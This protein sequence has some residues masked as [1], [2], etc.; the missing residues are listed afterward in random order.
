MGPAEAPALFRTNTQINE[1]I[2]PWFWEGTI[3]MLK[4]RKGCRAVNPNLAPVLP[5]QPLLDAQEGGKF[6][7]PQFPLASA[8]QDVG[9][10]IISHS[11]RFSPSLQKVQKQVVKRINTGVLNLKNNGSFLTK[12]LSPEHHP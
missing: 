8:A 6:K 10:R 11:S 2:L 7:A 4:S 3:Q 1:V 5:C 9:I 12:S